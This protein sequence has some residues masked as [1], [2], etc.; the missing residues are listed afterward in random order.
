MTMYCLTQID[1]SSL[2]RCASSRGPATTSSCSTS[3]LTVARRPSVHAVGDVVAS[4]GFV[5]LPQT[6]PSSAGAPS[7]DSTR[8]VVALP[9]CLERLLYID[10]VA[11]RSAMDRSL[12]KVH[13]ANGCFN[14]FKC[15]DSTTVKVLHVFL[16]SI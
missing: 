11:V 9:R 5:S 7:T 16:T 15:S 2:K 6:L 14:V 10:S 4:G 3:S 13:L 1:R 8:G 12:V